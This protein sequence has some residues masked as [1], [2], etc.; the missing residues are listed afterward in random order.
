MPPLR[1]LPGCG[2]LARSHETL[3]GKADRLHSIGLARTH[4]FHMDSFL[5]FQTLRGEGGRPAFAKETKAEDLH[6]L[7]K[8]KGTKLFLRSFVSNTHIWLY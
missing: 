1:S 7:R 8:P 2:P 4:C 5:E 6:L 3:R